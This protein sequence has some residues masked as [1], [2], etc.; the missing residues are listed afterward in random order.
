MRDVGGERT[1]VECVRRLSLFLCVLFCSYIWQKKKEKK[2]DIGKVGFRGFVE[3]ALII[4]WLLD[5][6]DLLMASFQCTNKSPTCRLQMDRFVQL[7]V[8]RVW[9][10]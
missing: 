9:G 6:K 1:D 5:Q 3:I 10:F 2:R 8:E 4:P 7:N